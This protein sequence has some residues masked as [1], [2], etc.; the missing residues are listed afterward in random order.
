MCEATRTLSVCI[1]CL[2]GWGPNLLAIGLGRDE[3]DLLA[4][5][6]LSNLLAIGVGRDKD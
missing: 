1:I 4:Q 3:S 5:G 2:K 6:I